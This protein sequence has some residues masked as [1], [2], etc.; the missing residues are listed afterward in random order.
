MLV[1]SSLIIIM[2]FEYFIGEVKQF[3]PYPF[4]LLALIFMCFKSFVIIHIAVVRTSRKKLSDLSF[5]RF[6]LSAFLTIHTVFL[7]KWYWTSFKGNHHKTYLTSM[8]VIC[9]HAFRHITQKSFASNK[10]LV[11][12]YVLWLHICH[13]IFVRCCL[14]L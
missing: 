3:L 10:L 2:P 9:L 13:T 12:F 6:V 1:Q 8:Y 14:D 7:R 4:I 5:S 11:D